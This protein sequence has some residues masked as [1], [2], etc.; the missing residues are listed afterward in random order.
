MQDMADAPRHG[1]C[2]RLDRFHRPFVTARKSWS[3]RRTDALSYGPNQLITVE[4]EGKA[5]AQRERSLPKAG[6]HESPRGY[7]G[8]MGVTTV[9]AVGGTVGY[10]SMLFGVA[11]TDETMAAIIDRY[12]PLM[13]EI[14]AEVHEA[15]A[16]GSAVSRDPNMGVLASRAALSLLWKSRALRLVYSQMPFYKVN[17]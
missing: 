8:D 4:V 16:R 5:L 11:L 17:G 7:E 15:A 6:A 12:R 2:V 14:A 9:G 3:T 1:S 10:A 13:V